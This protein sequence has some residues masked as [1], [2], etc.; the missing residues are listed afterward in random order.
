MPSI[1]IERGGRKIG[2]IGAILSSTPVSYIRK[3]AIIYGVRILFIS[4]FFF[5]RA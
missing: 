3:F 5:D 4:I 2:I 1:V